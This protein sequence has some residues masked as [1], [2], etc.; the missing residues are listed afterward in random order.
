MRRTAILT[1]LL[2]ALG[3][4]VTA[5][6]ARGLL[7]SAELQRRIVLWGIPAAALVLAA[8]CGREGRD[9]TRPARRAAG[10]AAV[11]LAFAADQSFLAA[12][13]ATGSVTFT[14]GAQELAGGRLAAAAL[15]ALPACVLL[16]VVGWERALRGGVYAGWRRRLPAPAA[17]ALSALAG[18][19]L[20]LPA[21]LPE[22]QVRDPG[23]VAAA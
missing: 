17:A 20:A 22:G 12:T 11:A 3:G 5:A 9:R 10:L 19:A 23:F 4:G 8:A 14:Q 16:G 13:Y 18:T 21:V 1:V 7:G 6:G 2:C 15:W